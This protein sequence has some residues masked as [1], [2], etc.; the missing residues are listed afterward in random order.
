[1]KRICRENALGY[2]LDGSLAPVLSVEPGEP[3][4]IETED[5]SSGN[6]TAGDREP[7]PENTPYVRF[8]PSK[9]NPV[10]GPVHVAGVE[11]GGRVCVEIVSIELAPTGVVYN[12]PPGTPLGDSSSWPDAGSYWLHTVRHTGGEAIVTD[13]L[14]WRAAP[15]IGT[16]ACAPE[17]EVRASSSG[18]GPW[19]GNLDVLDFCP[20]SSVVL[21]SYHPGG[22][23]FVGDVH[24]CQ[25]DGEYIGTADESRAEVVLRAWP[26]AGGFLPAPRVVTADRVVALGIARPLEAAADQAVRNLLDW[27]VAD[28]EF[29][30]REAYLTVAINPDF[31]LRVYQMTRSLR[32]TSSFGASVPRSYLG[33][34]Q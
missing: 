18:Q 13:R 21:S 5:A 8:S 23:L 15:M 32:S 27:L 16:L 7:T 4:A 24:G 19:G 11:A 9:A 28:Y 26:V 29:S 34:V 30:A 2:A 17:W 6:L 12:Q 33:G 25:G 20:G 3:F 31:R 10:G 22:L 1:M 14:C